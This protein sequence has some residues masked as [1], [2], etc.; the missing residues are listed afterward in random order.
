MITPKSGIIPPGGHHYEDE[1]G[2]IEG[3]SYEDVAEKLLRFRIAN[4]LPLGMPL[5]EVIHYTCSRHPHFCHSPQAP[6]AG[7]RRPP[8]SGRVIEWYSALYRGLRGIKVADNYVDQATADRRA[9]ICLKCPHHVEWRSGC[10]SCVEGARRIGYTYRAG[11][12]AEYESQ[13]MG[14]SIIGHDCATAVWVKAAP[15][16]TPETHSQLPDNCWKR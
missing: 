14:C 12:K 8:L 7:V 2:R 16:L 9:A 4:K 6:A 1:H 13:L 11:R 10:G 15:T 5:A 3:T